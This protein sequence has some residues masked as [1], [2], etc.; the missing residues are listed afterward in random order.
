MKL[1]P[2]S[3]QPKQA[4][5]HW[6]LWAAS[7]L[8][9]LGLILLGQ[10][11]SLLHAQ[12]SLDAAHQL[13]STLR[14]LN[15]LRN[16]SGLP[17]H[18]RNLLRSSRVG[19]SIRFRHGAHRTSLEQMTQELDIEFTRV[20]GKIAH[21]GSIY[22]AAIAWQELDR[23][24]LW[25]GVERV[26]SIWKPAM[27]AP[28]DTSIP[29]I[30]ADRVWNLLDSSGWP[31][32]GR[33]IVVADFDSGVDV[34]H[35][36]FWRADGGTYPWLDVNDNGA[37]DAGVDAID[38]NR[39]GLADS[40]ERL[41]FVDSTSPGSDNI[42]GTNDN[43]FQADVDWLYNDANGNGL[44]DFGPSSGFGE[45]N[46]TYGERLFLVQDTNDNGALD[47]G[48]LLLALGTCK[49]YK[50]LDAQGVE[51]T[52][53]VDLINN[54]PD[55]EGHGT[56]VCSIL[57]GGSVGLRRYVGVAPG[58]TLLVADRY[59]NDY[60]T[61]IPWAEDNGAQ[62]MLYEFGSWIQEFMDG[63]SNLEQMLDSEAAKGIVQVVPAGNL[64]DGQKH[65]HMILAAS[66]SRD[67]RF[68]VPQGQQL[69]EA[70]LS[71]LWRAPE[72]AV[73]LQLI[74][75]SGATV[76]LPGDE[77]TVS[78]DG[79]YIISAQDRSPRGTSRFDV[80]VY[81][82]NADLAQG[83]WTLRLH[84]NTPS[85][86]DVHAYVSDNL[87]DWVQ[88]ITFL[89]NADPMYT[90]TA[91]G[92][93][94]SA[95]TVASYSTRG[96]EGY[97]AGALSPFSGQ[98]PRI[99]GQGV[100]DVAAPGHYDI[101]CARSKDVTGATL[102]QYAWF[103]GTSAAAPHAAGA[104]ALLL[105]SAP[106]LSPSQIKQ[107]LHNTA[108]QDTYTGLVPNQRWGYGKL[109]IWAAVPLTPTPTPTL[110]PVTP[111]PTPRARIFLP[112]VTKAL[113]TQ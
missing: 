89:D 36:D 75:P 68:E 51:H 13:D 70:W 107:M 14:L 111:S 56:Q 98:G 45:T 44:R 10:A 84:N 62:I 108:R 69:N 46:P 67:V 53:G 77:S 38:L 92:T 21:V 32:T 33:G 60:T 25:P 3:N 50:T 52:R 30:G 48:E 90:V 113:L 64:A 83:D 6:Q 11:P 87:S 63:S 88:G 59:Y 76:S 109:D 18:M 112:I 42:P 5:S 49:V 23:L 1:S 43:S 97:I 19:V 103:G 22:G 16:R 47:I 78:A 58:I 4:N 106:S 73:N 9:A 94:D 35:P 99:D 100:L 86:L 61:Y 104:A 15:I 81:R 28:L 40:S 12:K 7:L 54:P 31:I 57:C 95:I 29:E 39:D 71:I 17:P 26:D 20:N 79:H 41:D 82:D 80:Y 85:W 91:P 101:A 93:A 96:R 110:T 105:Q 2:H 102:G 66:S 72:D 37:F 8:F 34:F 27:L 74:T 24:A 55:E 65:A